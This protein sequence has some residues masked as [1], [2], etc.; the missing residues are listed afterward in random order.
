MWLVSSIYI[1][2]KK[3]LVFTFSLLSMWRGDGVILVLFP[4]YASDKINEGGNEGKM[5]RA[6]YVEYYNERPLLSQHLNYTCKK[7]HVVST[8]HLEPSTIT[9]DGLCIMHKQ[10]VQNRYNSNLKLRFRLR[11]VWLP[12]RIPLIGRK[13]G[14][15]PELCTACAQ[16]RGLRPYR[17]YARDCKSCLRL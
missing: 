14:L 4:T 10:A 13:S 9:C 17:T 16:G 12:I 5:G 2:T 1:Y 8:Q 3:I 15:W 7:W 11:F 6:W